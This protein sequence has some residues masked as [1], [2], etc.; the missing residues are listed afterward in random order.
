M[1]R[2]STAI[3]TALVA[4]LL[5]WVVAVPFG[6]L[7]DPIQGQLPTS[8]ALT[9]KVST[10][11]TITTTAPITGGGDLS[12]N[13]TFAI[14]AASGAAAGS[15][16]AADF[17]KLSGLGTGAN[18]IGAASSTDNA[19][20]R[21]DGTGGKT[22]QNSLVTLSDADLLTIP[23]TAGA[24][25]YIL[26]NADPLVERAEHS[27][28]SNIYSIKTLG[29]TG[30]TFVVQ[31]GTGA[32]ATFTSSTSTGSSTITGTVTTGAGP[33]VRLADGS[34]MTSSSLVQVVGKVD[35][36][37]VQSSTAGYK[38]LQVVVTETSTGSGQK[39][40]LSLETGAGVRSRVDNL[41]QPSFVSSTA[42]PA[43]GAVTSCILVSS[44]SSLGFC[45]GAGAPTFSAAQ[46]T[47]YTNT[48]GGAGARLYTNTS[49]STTWTAATSP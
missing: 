13:R 46:G 26:N 7:A 49:G 37:A 25:L 8:S 23:S 5:A 30:R 14:S 22:F 31:A 48:T 36:T 40:L 28:A 39:D 35:A 4:T 41:G 11:T 6:V 45:W 10:S 12:T 19:L 15:M 3:L 47:L 43:N 21:M 32:S 33:A 34:N 27:W 2:S 1:K 9:A 16:S 20:C 17:T 24:G 44:T 38:G 29:T 18:A 42:P